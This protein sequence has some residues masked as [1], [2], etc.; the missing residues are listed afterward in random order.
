MRVAVKVQRPAARATVAADAALLR[1]AARAVE[2][3]RD[4]RTGEKLVRARA[5]AAVD[6]FMV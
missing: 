3:L 2:A 5:L 1:S 4:P 6:E